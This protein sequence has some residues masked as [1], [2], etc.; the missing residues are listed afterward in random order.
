VKRLALYV[1]ISCQRLVSGGNG[2]VQKKLT[3]DALQLMDPLPPLQYSG[4]SLRRFRLHPCLVAI[5]AGGRQGKGEEGK[6]GN[7]NG[8]HVCLM[9]SKVS[10]DGERYFRYEEFA[11][12]DTVLLDWRALYTTPSEY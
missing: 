1:E 10:I 7:C 5:S 6:D 11:D 3:H 12:I 8:A 2:G 9:N 4:Q